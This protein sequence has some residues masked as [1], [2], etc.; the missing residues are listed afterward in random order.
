MCY[1][2]GGEGKDSEMTNGI[3]ILFFAD[4]HL[5]YDMAVQ[6]RVERRRRGDDFFSN[7]KLILDFTRRRKVDLIVHGGDLFFRSKVSPAILDRAYEPLFSVASAGIP[8][9]IVPGN[10]ERSRLPE[11]LYLA[12]ENIHIFDRP[13]SFGFEKAGKWIVLSGFP[14]ARKARDK[15]PDLLAQTGYKD[16]EADVR[17]LCTHQTYQG[18]QVGPVDFTFKEGP[19]NIPPE[20]VPGDFSAVL[21]GHIHR[22]QQLTRTLKGKPLKVPVIYPGSIERT[23][24][25]E[26]FEEK[27]FCLITLSWQKGELE[28]TLEWLPLPAR[29]MVKVTVPVNDYPADQVLVHIRSQLA[30]LKPDAVV[31]VEL[32]GS[33]ADK[34]QGAISASRLRDLGP[35][36]MN[37]TFGLNMGL[38]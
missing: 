18:A 25:A 2:G 30:L 15:F 3:K 5:G 19:D 35:G 9:F 8:I 28:Q 26:R 4:T 22:G 27:S 20:W 11:H 36:S 7:Y 34:V 6:P 16:T 38:T 1:N 21:S 32:V 12:H 17:F 33:R 23:S 37:I 29:P 24:I 10:H 13:T 14:F 31:R